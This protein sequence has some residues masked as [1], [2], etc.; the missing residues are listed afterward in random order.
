MRVPFFVKGFGM[1]NFYIS[2][3]TIAAISTSMGEAG[4][5]IVRVSGPKAFSIGLSVFSHG[6]G[7][8]KADVKKAF[9]PTP[10]MLHYGHIVDGNEV[11][12]E[13]L[14]SFMPGPNTF[15][16]D[17]TV[18]I[19]CHGGVLS[20]RRIL[21]LVLSKGAR[22]A[23]GGE[24]TRRAFLNGR[25]DLTQAE[26]IID[27]IDAK[28]EKAHQA[29]V[30]QL[31]GGVSSPIRALR[32]QVL[33]LL[34][35]VEYAINFMEDAQEEL[36]VEPM[37]AQGR[38]IAAKIEAMIESNNRG[39]I[40]KEGIHTVIVGKPN[41]GKS[42]LL[43][44]LLNENRAIVTDI[45]GTTRDAIDES[46]NLGGIP[47]HLVDTAG[48]RDTDDVVEQIG[49]SKSLELVEQAD[50]VLALFDG[51]TKREEDDERILGLIRG[52]KAIVLI[53]KRDLGSHHSDAE[54]ETWVRNVNPDAKVLYTSILL[55]EGVEALEEQVLALFFGGEISPDAEGMITN[56]RHKDLLVRARDALVNA[57]SDLEMGI[58]IDAIEIDLHRTYEALLE[59][60]G[61]QVDD[62][63]LDKIFSDFC[64]G[65]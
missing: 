3:D 51:S 48:I 55:K 1:A 5:G 65:K 14:V 2:E 63:V 47:L 10:R 34:A 35:H 54:M 40:V 11:I 4:I 19:N 6:K 58:A 59:I 36:P 8:S 23:E 37:I 12:D 13:V 18:E 41:V 44:A 45:P 30:S 60:L 61:E 53:N 9:T 31:D 7:G 46:L 26:A 49:V 64:V 20:V 17:D 43:N 38:D 33:N 56:I 50:L 29:A 21:A 57:C 15:T 52:K 28:T 16:G 22:A 25:L 32:D 42:S 27:V 62:D 39:R 24:F